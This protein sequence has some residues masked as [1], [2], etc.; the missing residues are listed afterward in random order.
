MV[1]EIQSFRN[2]ARLSIKEAGE[3]DSLPQTSGYLL[4]ASTIHRPKE[5]NP[6]NNEPIKRL[7]REFRRWMNRIRCVAVCGGDEHTFCQ[8]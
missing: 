7:S 4:P 6:D 3:D 8:R 5:I 1:A 2:S